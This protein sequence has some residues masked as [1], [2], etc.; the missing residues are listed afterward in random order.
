MKVQAILDRLKNVRSRG[1]GQWSACCPSHEDD[2]PSLSIQGTDGKILVH[3]FAGCT[4][5]AITAALG[6]EM[7]DLRTDT[8]NGH[9][10][11]KIERVFSYLNEA[12]ELLYETVREDLPNGKKSF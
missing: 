11:R 6:V 8:I 4:V 10:F 9:T 7:K 3:C 2:S 1:L 12:G 5:S